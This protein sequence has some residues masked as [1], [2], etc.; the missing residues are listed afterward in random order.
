VSG[1]NIRAE[2]KIESDLLGWLDDNIF[3]LDF[4]KIVKLAT[5]ERTYL[6]PSKYPAVVRDIALLVDR[7][8]KVIEVLNLINAAG[9]RLI[10]DVD[11]FDI[12]EGEEILDG[13]KNLAFHIIYQADDHTLTD[14]EV[15]KLQEKI[16]KSLEEEG[17][18]EV[19]R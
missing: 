3:E 14:K 6:P 5:E 13:K 10:R 1:E 11:L 15:N 12:Y 4:E 7:G 9:G 17:G 18:W 16:I 19:R 2:V 8:T